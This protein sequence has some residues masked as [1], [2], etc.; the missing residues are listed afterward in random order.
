M[1]NS[2]W[3]LLKSWKKVKLETVR[4]IAAFEDKHGPMADD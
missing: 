3:I 1:V 4:K 2:L